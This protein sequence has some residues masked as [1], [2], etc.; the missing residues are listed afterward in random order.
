MIKGMNGYNEAQATNFASVELPKLAPGGYVLA[1]NAV[2]VEDTQY[3]ARLAFMFDIAEGEFKGFFK[4]LYDMTPKTWGDVKWKGSY[5]LYIP[6]NKGDADKYAKAVGF[7]KSQ[8]EAFEQSN[9]GLKINAGG[10]WD[11]QILAR[12]Y[13]GA[14]FNEKEWEMNGKTGF[15]TQCKRFV[16]VN[17]IRSG[18]F[19]IP[20]ADLLKRNTNTGFSNFGGGY[21]NNNAGGFSNYLASEIPPVPNGL[22]APQTMQNNYTAPAHEPPEFTGANAEFQVFGGDDSGVP[23]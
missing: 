22:N 14:I 21:G 23:F 3:G 5:R 17:D 4:K 7:F 1:V 2:K 10:D 11:E 19:T 6:V 18:N 16:S 9:P 8:L 12:K 13:V 15:F 20:K